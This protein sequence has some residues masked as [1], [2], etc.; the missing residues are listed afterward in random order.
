MQD[1]KDTRQTQK[2]ECIAILQARITDLR[3]IETFFKRF[4]VEMDKRRIA[5]IIGGLRKVIEY[6]EKS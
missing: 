3:A 6:I 2:D 1:Y 5:N 4:G